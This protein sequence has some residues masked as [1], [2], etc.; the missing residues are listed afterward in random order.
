[1]EGKGFQFLL[2]LLAHSLW[3]LNLFQ[4]LLHEQMPL[5]IF[6]PHSCWRIKRPVKQ[7]LSYSFRNF[8]VWSLSFP[9]SL[10]SLTLFSSIFFNPGIFLQSCLSINY[11]W[12][13]LYAIWTYCL[14]C[15]Y[16]H[17]SFFR[18][19][20]SNFLASGFYCYFPPFRLI[21]YG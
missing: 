4:T 15:S 17:T 2:I 16:M 21:K 18:W 12:S 6:S 9:Y 10:C 1:M 14:C 19:L 7:K 20:T 5:W 13:F 8:T 11:I 3:N